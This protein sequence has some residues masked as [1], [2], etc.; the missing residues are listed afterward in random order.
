MT[1]GWWRFE[2]RWCG[3]ALGAVVVLGVL[4]RVHHVL[5]LAD[6]PTSTHPTMDALYHV[7]WAHSMV[8]GSTFVEEAYFRLP[9]YPFFLSICERLLGPDLEV[10]RLA[11]AGL[12]VRADPNRSEK[13]GCGHI[14]SVLFGIFGLYRNQRRSPL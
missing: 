1:G 8:A 3:W 6:L 4:L 2:R 14:S 7:Q 11:Q 9:L 5:R 10:W 12:G 13:V